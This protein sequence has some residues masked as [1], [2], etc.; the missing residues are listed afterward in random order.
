[1]KIHFL[2]YTMSNL[3]INSYQPPCLWHSGV[4][5]VDMGNC[6]LRGHQIHSLVVLRGFWRHFFDIFLA[7]F[8]YR[9]FFDFGSSLA[10]K[11]PQK[12]TTNLKKQIIRGFVLIGFWLIFGRFW[13]PTWPPKLITMIN[14]ISNEFLKMAISP[15][16]FKKSRFQGIK[17]STKNKLKINKKQS[18]VWSFFDRFWKGFWELRCFQNP[19]PQKIKQKMK[20]QIK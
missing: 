20:Q 12:S 10:F 13:R 3:H 5:W 1:M 8:F 2:S 17:K 4:F 19:H 15:E 14:K 6:I 16:R 9:F 7:S 11:T 18:I